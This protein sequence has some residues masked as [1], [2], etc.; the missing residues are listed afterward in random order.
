MHEGQSD[1]LQ[2][3]LVVFCED[4]LK[5]AMQQH[6]ERAGLVLDGLGK[7]HHNMTAIAHHKQHRMV[8]VLGKE[9][10]FSLGNEARF[11]LKIASL[12]SHPSIPPHT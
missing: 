5:A 2:P 3:T 7:S 12:Y 8:L 1:S 11:I 6:K 10:S 4:V 9:T